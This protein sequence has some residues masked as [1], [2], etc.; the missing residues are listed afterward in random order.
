MG[1]QTAASA[2]AVVVQLHVGHAAD[3][4]FNVVGIIV[5]SKH[6]EQLFLRI[7]RCVA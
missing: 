1:V 7:M 5:V 3:V 2:A 6:Q 4:I